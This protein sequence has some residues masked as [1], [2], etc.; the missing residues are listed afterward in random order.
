M[1][2]SGEKKGRRKS[3][4]S[5]TW[6]SVIH[7][8]CNVDCFP[9]LESVLDSG[10][11]TVF[12]IFFLCFFFFWPLQEVIRVVLGNLDDLHPFSTDHF[13]VFPCI[14]SFLLIKEKIK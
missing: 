13:T 1:G 3:R 14:L 2:G 12:L 5:R 4:I 9:S 10:I 7:A 11:V 6:S 8:N